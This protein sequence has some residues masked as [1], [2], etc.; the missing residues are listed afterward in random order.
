[1]YSNEQWPIPGY[2]ERPVPNTFYGKEPRNT[3]LAV[4]FPGFAYTSQAPLFRYLIQLLND[5]GCDVLSVDYDY[6]GTQI[7][8]RRTSRSRK[9][10]SGATSR[11]SMPR[12]TPAGNTNASSSWAN[13]LGP[14]PCFTCSR[15]GWR[16]RT[17][18]SSG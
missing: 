14:R 2:R 1:M 11:R 13:P 5:R 10:G 12:S 6:A 7:F 8:C 18:V 17:S 16:T 3:R 9:S 4:T 15:R